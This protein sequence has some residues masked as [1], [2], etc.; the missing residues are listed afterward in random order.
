MSATATQA[1]HECP[2]CVA[3]LEQFVHEAEH[4]LVALRAVLG[5]L[6]EVAVGGQDVLPGERIGE[7][8]ADCPDLLAA[9]ADVAAVDL[10]I[11]DLLEPVTAQADA[12]FVVECV[13]GGD[14]LLYTSPSP[15]D[16]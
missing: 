14:C 8:R 9:A 16:S 11:T 3:A 10:G 6:L 13:L 12:E 1:R 15:R 7:A 4:E 5:V 2:A